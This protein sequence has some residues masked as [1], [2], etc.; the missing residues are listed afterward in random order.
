MSLDG[1]YWF[2]PEL[3]LGLLEPPAAFKV[4]CS[5]KRRRKNGFRQRSNSNL[6][7]MISSLSG[8]NP[9]VHPMARKLRFGPVC[10][11]KFVFTGI[12]KYECHTVPELSA[13]NAI[14]L[15]GCPTLFLKP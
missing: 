14:C 9:T 10:S 15:L 6:V 11:H 1:Y 5:Q 13:P 2:Q 4:N 3:K 7:Q 12:L 8:A